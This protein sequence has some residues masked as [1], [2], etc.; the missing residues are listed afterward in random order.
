MNKCLP[1]S[2][3]ITVD[4]KDIS[5]PLGGKHKRATLNKSFETP[6]VPIFIFVTFIFTFSHLLIF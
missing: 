4:E 5:K 6:V 2:K 1:F 3:G